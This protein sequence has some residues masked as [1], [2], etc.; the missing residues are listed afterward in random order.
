M[1]STDRPRRCRERLAVRLATPGYRATTPLRTATT[2]PSQRFGL[3]VV[4]REPVTFDVGVVVVGVGRVPPAVVTFD[5]QFL[6]VAVV[7]TVCDAVAFDVQLFGAVVGTVCD[8]VA[9]DV[10]L[11]GAVVGTVCDAVAFDVQLF[12][13]VVG[14]VC[15]AMAFDVQVVPLG[16]VVHVVLLRVVARGVRAGHTIPVWALQVRKADDTVNVGWL[17]VPTIARSDRARCGLSP[18]FAILPTN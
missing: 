10:Q 3:S 2:A 13:A 9:F 11:F 1:Q 7:G 4:V 17:T 14:T 18:S 8:A 15:D 16:C 6:C 12:G 5:V